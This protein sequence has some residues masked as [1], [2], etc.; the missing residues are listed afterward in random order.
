MNTFHKQLRAARLNKATEGLSLVSITNFSSFTA[1]TFK[2]Y[3][4]PYSFLSKRDMPS[5]GDAYAISLISGRV[6]ILFTL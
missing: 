6:E 1:V 4:G 5:F 3:I 2:T